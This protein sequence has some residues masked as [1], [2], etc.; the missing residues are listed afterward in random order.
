ML[1]LGIGLLGLAALQARSVRFNHDAHARGQAAYLATQ[2][3]EGL[4]SDPTGAPAYASTA[5]AGR[6]DPAAVSPANEM[7][8]WAEA[9]RTLLPRGRGSV[10]LDGEQLEVVVRWQERSARDPRSK[11]SCEAVPGRVWE[12]DEGCRESQSCCLVSQ[13]WTVRP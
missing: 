6:C 8:C 4:H 10:T 2:I 3:A 12:E 5:P 1:V 11:T 13:A 7:A 9:L